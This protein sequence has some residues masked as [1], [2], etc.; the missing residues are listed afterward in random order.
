[1]VHR[2][3]RGNPALRENIQLLGNCK[4]ICDDKNQFIKN[5]VFFQLIY[6]LFYSSILF[7]HF[8]LE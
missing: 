7:S 8:K 6:F 2:V 1:M 5:Y 4:D 3:H